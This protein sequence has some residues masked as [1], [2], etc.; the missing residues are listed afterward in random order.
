MDEEWGMSSGSE[1]APSE[2]GSSMKDTV[3][4]VDESCESIGGSGSEGDDTEEV[5]A[6]SVGVSGKG[7][8]RKRRREPTVEGRRWRRKAVGDGFMFDKE[9]RGLRGVVPISVRERCMLEKICKFNKTLELDQKEAIE[10][11]MLKLILEYR[12]FSMQRELTA[13][14]MKAWVPQRKAFRLVGRLVPFSVYEVAL[15][16]GLPVTG[17]VVEF[18]EDDLST[19]EL[20]RMV[21]LPM[22]YYVT[23]KSDNLKGKKGRKRPVFRN[24]IKVMKKLLD[25]NKELE[26]LGLWL[27]LYDAFQLVEGI[28]ESKVI[29]V[30]CPREEEMLEPTVRAFMKTDGF[31]DYILDGEVALSYEECLERASEELR[32]EKGKHVDTLRMLE[33]WKSRAHELEARLKRCTAPTAPQD[34]RHYPGGDV[35][36]DAQSG[37]D[38]MVGA[39]TNMG[40]AIVHESSLA[41][42][43]DEDA[44]CQTIAGIPGATYDDQSTPQRMAVSAEARAG[45]L[46]MWFQTGEPGIV[47]NKG[48]ISGVIWD[49]FKAT[50]QSDVRYVFMPLLETTDGH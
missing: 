40:E 31:R 41:K 18:G 17:K 34:A 3:S 21:R 28:K 22:A 39:I 27:S 14:L 20:E 23:E 44:T 6:D 16:I 19:T 36:V 26:K 10:R 47:R 38:S 4:M 12:P 15:F 8:S 30:L 5:H 24:Y 32:A 25:A 9:G 43:A 35:E 2:A 46:S 1:Y 37:L 29:L 11:M 42:G 50:P 13:A 45:K 49:N 7:K 33:F 48:R